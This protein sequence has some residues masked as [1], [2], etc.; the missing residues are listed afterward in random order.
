ALKTFTTF[1]VVLSNDGNTF[2]AAEHQIGDKRNQNHLVC[3]TLGTGIG[4][5]VI[6]DGRVIRGLWG[7]GSELGHIT[8]D[9]DGPICNCGSR[10]CIEAYAS[11]TGIARQM[12]AH[13]E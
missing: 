3:L 5:G 1:T 2:A 6:S 10:G 12:G 7:G 11:G 9:S 4:G 13:I 8:V